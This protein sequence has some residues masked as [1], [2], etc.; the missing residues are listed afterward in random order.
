M[1]YTGDKKRE[2][3]R[4]WCREKRTRWIKLKGPCRVCGSTNQLEFDHIDPSTKVTHRLWG[5]SEAK[6]A[7]E[8]SKCQVLCRPCHQEKTELDQRYA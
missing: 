5:Y 2:Y 7:A 4:N 1:S 3:Q 8:L 6:I